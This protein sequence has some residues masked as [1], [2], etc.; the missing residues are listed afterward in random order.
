M[1]LRG[2]GW[3]VSF[4]VVVSVVVGLCWGGWE[5]AS[6][7]EGG[8][9][10]IERDL[11]GASKLTTG[12]LNVINSIRSNQSFGPCSP[13][14]FKIFV[15]PIK[16]PAQTDVSRIKIYQPNQPTDPLLHPHSYTPKK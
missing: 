16:C 5:M 1:G 9:D 11:T 3:F 4:V 7:R 8:K 14:L 12:P 2:E 15:A 10:G 13:L 6:R